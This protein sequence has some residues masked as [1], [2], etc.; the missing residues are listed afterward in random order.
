LFWLQQLT[1]FGED[2]LHENIRL[3]DAKPLHLKSRSR[4]HEDIW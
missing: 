1:R 3:A 4:A 2:G